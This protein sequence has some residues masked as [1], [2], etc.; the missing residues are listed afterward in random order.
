M[1]YRFDIGIVIKATL[2]KI[3]ESAILLILRTNLK[4]FYDCLVKLGSTQEKQLMVNI[5]KRST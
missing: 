4:F 3:L 2:E 5:I 1:A